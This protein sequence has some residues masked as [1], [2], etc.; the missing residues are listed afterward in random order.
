MYRVS[1]CVIYLENVRRE[2]V[3]HILFLFDFV[4]SVKNVDELSRTREFVDINSR[5]SNN[6]PC[7]VFVRKNN[8]I[9]SFPENKR[10]HTSFDTFFVTFH[11]T[12]ERQH[13][14]IF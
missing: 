3:T 13:S 10:L 8:R 7:F 2:Y 1:V 6:A 12:A 9:R 5:I 11:S 14:C 4:T